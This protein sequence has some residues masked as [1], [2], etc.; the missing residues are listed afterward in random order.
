MTNENSAAGATMDFNGRRWIS[1]LEASKYLDC[2]LMT[3]YGWIDSGKIPAV[4]IGRTVRVDFRALE[5]G[6]A[7]Q[8]NGR[9]FAMRAKAH[10]RGAT[11]KEEK[12]LSRA[13]N[14]EVCTMG[15]ADDHR[16]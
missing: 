1:P 9:P 14:E 4:K 6:L 11:R 3:I 7:R 15:H 13:R 5:N 2:H 12:N 10:D 16:T 8:I